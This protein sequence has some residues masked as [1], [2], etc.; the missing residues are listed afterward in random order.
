M[1]IIEVQASYEGDEKC[2]KIMTQLSIN[3]STHP[4]YSLKHEVLRYKGRLYVGS[5]TELKK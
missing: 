1:W 3:A 4:N 2:K 5:Q